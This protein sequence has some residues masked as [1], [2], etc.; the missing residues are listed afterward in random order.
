MRF[1]LL[2][3]LLLCTLSQSA[4]AFLEDK[5]ARRKITE[6]QEQNQAAFEQLRKNQQALEERLAA[7]EAIV[8][9]QGL[10]DLLNQVERLNQELSR[11]KGELEVATH[12]IVSLQ[13][14]Q[15]D[16]YA[17]ADTRLRQLEAGGQSAGGEDASA[18]EAEVSGEEAAEFDAAMELVK[19][20]KY[21]EAFDALN[22]FTQTY[23]N[24]GRMPDALYA[25]G[26]SQFSLKNY[27]AAI[28]TQEKVVQRYPDHAR[29]AD[30]LFN[31]ANAQIQLSE[32]D[33]AK[34]TLRGLLDK[35]PSSPVAPNAQQRLKV[36]ESIK[37]R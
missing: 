9:G 1:S 22:K 24:S 31:I 30:A 32:V 15:R 28:A 29:A 17:D 18:A 27:R 36:L 35:Y 14:R 11:V 8:K 13:Q 12:N 33:G 34:K 23:P 6:N 19:A 2:V 21:R 3:T 20:S 4:Y 16:L 5:E 26:F 37:S 25:L 10:L 7:I